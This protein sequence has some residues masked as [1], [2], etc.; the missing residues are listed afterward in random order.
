MVEMVIKLKKNCSREVHGGCAE[1]HGGRECCITE[2]YRGC[3]EVHGGG[4][5]CS[6]EVHRGWH[7]GTRR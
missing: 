5:C 7:R 6:T 4:E 2:F 3:A 1:V